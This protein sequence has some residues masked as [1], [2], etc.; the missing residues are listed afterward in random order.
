MTPNQICKRVESLSGDRKGVESVWELIERFVLP[1]RGEFYGDQN[2][3]SVDWRK[4]SIYDS[5]A[6]DSA[7]LLSASIHSNLTSLANR[8]FDLN[9]EDKELNDNPEYK[10]W[11]DNAQDTVWQKLIESNF[12][13]K[14]GEAYLD[15]VGFGNT[16]MS[17]DIDEADGELLFDAIPINESLF[18]QDAKGNLLR[19]YRCVK[20]TPLQIVEK[21][22]TNDETV[23]AKMKSASTDKM[24]VIFAVYKR[25][26]SKMKGSLDKSSKMTIGKMPYAYKWILKSNKVVLKE[27]AYYDMPF[28]FVPWRRTTGSVWG[29]GPATRSLSNILTLNE[30][31]EQMLEGTAKAIDP[32]IFTTK[33]NLLSDVNITRGGLTTVRDLDEFR[34]FVTNARFDIGTKQIEDLKKS[35]E[36]SFHIDSLQLKESPQMTA[37]EVNVRYDMIQKLLGP[38]LGRIQVHLLD[39]IIERIFFSLLREDKLG[40]MP[41]DLSKSKININYVGPLPRAQQ[42]KEAQSIQEFLGVVAELAATY[43]EARHIPNIPKIL[44]ELAKLKGVNMSYLNSQ[45]EVEALTEDEVEAQQRMQEAEIAKTQGEAQNQFSQSNNAGEQI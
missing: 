6:V 45:D 12:D 1:F 34:E 40:A 29:N 14:I 25:D 23:M 18:E 5:T 26:L 28:Y 16:F 11:L 8:W 2:E 19:F 3:R 17:L 15:L 31:V 24:E 37:T 4:R 39:P 9:F 44:P 32:P 38:T 13:L 10:G 22:N 36:K 35:I 7:E 43:P 41:G 30:I 20:Y 33:K 21:F 42:Y 27:G